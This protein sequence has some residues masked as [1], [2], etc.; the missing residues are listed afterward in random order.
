MGQTNYGNQN[1][2]FDYKE[3]AKGIKFNR[4]NYKLLSHG[5]YSGGDITKVTGQSYHISISPFIAYVETAVP[6][7]PT[8]IGVRIETTTAVNITLN[9]VSDKFVVGRFEWIN[10]ENN[11]M[12]FL[13]VSSPL[14]SDIIFGKLVFTGGNV[15]DVSATIDVSQK[16]YAFNYYYGT[17]NYNPPL[18]V[19]A[20]DPYSTVVKVSPGKAV[21]NGKVVELTQLTTSPVFSNV[22]TGRKDIL[23]L[24][25]DGSLYIEEGVESGSPVL[26]QFK[27]EYL[28]LAVIS[29]SAGATDVRGADITYLHPL[30][31]KSGQLTGTDF[32]T[33]YLNRDDNTD[34]VFFDT[35]DSAISP[36]YQF[37]QPSSDSFSY[38]A[39]KNNE[40]TDYRRIKT[41]GI[42]FDGHELVREYIYG[43]YPPSD[44]DLP[45]LSIKNTT[46][47]S[48]VHNTPQKHTILKLEA[49]NNP[50]TVKREATISLQNIY[51]VGGTTKEFLWDI[52]FHNLTQEEDWSGQPTRAI[53]AV[54]DFT[55]GTLLDY[56]WVHESKVNYSN[57]YVYRES[58]ALKG[59]TG[60]LELYGNLIPTSTITSEVSASN[61]GASATRYATVYSNA[62]DSKASVTTPL[63]I[64]TNLKHTDS[65]NNNIVLA[66]S[67]VTINSTTLSTQAISGTTITS[68]GGIT[69]PTLKHASASGT[70]VTLNSDGTTT[71]LGLSC[72]SLTSSGAISGTTITGSGALSGATLTLGG[73][74]LGSDKLLVT[75]GA[76]VTSTLVVEG[77][78]TTK[79]I[80]TT[81]TIAVAG[82]IT[83]TTS[84]AATTSLSAGTTLSVAQLSTLTGGINTSTI[85]ASGTVTADNLVPNSNGTGSIGSSGTKYG[86]GYFNKCYGAVGNDY[87]DIYKHPIEEKDI[88]FGKVYVYDIHT[89]SLHLSTKYAEKNIVGIASN[90]YSYLAGDGKGIPISVGG[91]LDVSLPVQYPIGTP[92]T[93]GPEGKL[94]KANM[95]IKLFFPERIIAKVVGYN[96]VKVL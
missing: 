93:C 28:P 75:G 36:V 17:Q 2:L 41:S 24:K 33:F 43:D 4:I 14:S 94:Y 88:K 40:G 48:G 61:I 37:P 1:L 5:I 55:G 66:A 10:T 77:T 79:N 72:A 44:K 49:P 30:F 29:R 80:N 69:S 34:G 16:S 56:V 76:K 84:I 18:K 67:S 35:L 6:S 8:N 46:L 64:A 83:A 81:G 45:C 13:V 25:Q 26:K 27:D 22:T 12:D 23:Y 59:A 19:V 86:A 90:Q 15:T 32:E 21:I 60:N 11:F 89:D 31:H 65:A 58:M 42:H 68:S 74:T 50:T 52:S 51:D 85:S 82:N 96:K 54:K 78:A 47:T 53:N 7:V 95:F 87:A 20:S 39:I 62:V 73:G 38:L 3:E 91:F 57:P 63:V 9:N 70:N 71:T 92:L